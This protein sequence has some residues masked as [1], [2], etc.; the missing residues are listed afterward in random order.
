MEPIT[1][2]I[3]GSTLLSMYSQYQAGEA[4]A[5][6]LEDQKALGL[7]AANE[8]LLRAKFNADMTIAEG[9]KIQGEQR[10]IYAGMGVDVNTGSPLDMAHETAYNAFKESKKIM[11]EANFNASMQRAGAYAY[12]EEANRTRT[13]SLLNSFAT[14]GESYA[15]YKLATG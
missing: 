3:I 10:A 7:M 1:G 9:R 5:D 6:S 14:A 8:T 12:G 15:K 2:V 4:R 11:R 13:T